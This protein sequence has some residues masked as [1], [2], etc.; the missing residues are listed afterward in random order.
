MIIE[1]RDDSADRIQGFFAN[2]SEWRRPGVD[3]MF[4]DESAC[5]EQSSIFVVIAISQQE[6][7]VGIGGTSA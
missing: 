2:E 7:L 6:S 4:L 3:P 5:R 1:E